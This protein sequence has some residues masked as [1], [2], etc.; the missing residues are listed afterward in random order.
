[1][2]DLNE[3]SNYGL[4][5]DDIKELRNTIDSTAII[6]AYTLQRMWDKLSELEIPQE[7][8]IAI[9]TQQKGENK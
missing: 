4:D 2:V 7:V 8:K 9:M 5:D 1:M 6:T 3:L